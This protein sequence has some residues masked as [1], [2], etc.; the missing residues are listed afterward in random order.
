[1]MDTQLKSVSLVFSIVIATVTDKNTEN[2]Q[3]VLA[4]INMKLFFFFS[5]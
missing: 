1:M 5:K 3:V 2:D 4:T